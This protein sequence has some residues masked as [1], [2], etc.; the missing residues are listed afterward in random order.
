MLCV[1]I[2]PISIA[3]SNVSFSMSSEQEGRVA[4]EGARQQLVSPMT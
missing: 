1:K 3:F 4:Q 2:D